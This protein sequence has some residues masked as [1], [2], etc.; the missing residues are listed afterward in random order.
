MPEMEAPHKDPA[1]GS[2]FNIA[3]SQTEKELLQHALEEADG[4]KSAAA[5]ALGMKLSTFRD[6][7]KKHRL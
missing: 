3:V 5:R 4:N 1:A 2:R 7:L 6:K